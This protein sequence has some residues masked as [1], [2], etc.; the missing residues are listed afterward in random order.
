M[1]T[2]KQIDAYRARLAK[3]DD[4]NKLTHESLG[5]VFTGGVAGEPD[6]VI[7]TLMSIRHSMGMGL[8]GP[9]TYTYVKLCPA[10][11]HQKSTG[12]ID[13]EEVMVTWLDSVV[14]NGDGVP[15]LVVS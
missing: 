6:P 7:G 1:A 5:A 14:R 15:A 11:A 4:Q 8:F 12:C 3:I 13:P 10:C 9:T 2:K